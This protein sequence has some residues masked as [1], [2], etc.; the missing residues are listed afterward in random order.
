MHHLGLHLPQTLHQPRVDT[1]E[2]VGD[3]GEHE[4]AHHLRVPES[5]PH[6]DAGS[7][8]EAEEVGL[9]DPELLE[10]GDGVVCHLLHGQRAIDVGGA[11]VGLHLECDHP[12]GLG[13]FR[14]DATERGADRRESAV[15]QDQRL[16]RAAIL[17]VHL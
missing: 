14:Q 6:G 12:P 10:G 5:N 8:A 3:R 13:E 4:F 2:S 9:F 17:V 16:S 1:V 11:P 7:H 15:E